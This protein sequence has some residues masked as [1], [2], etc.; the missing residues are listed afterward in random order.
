MGAVVSATVPRI[1]MLRL[2]ERADR[3]QARAQLWKRAA[4]HNRA[5]AII[6]GDLVDRPPK[7][8]LQWWC[9][10]CGLQFPSMDAMRTH[11]GT[12]PKHPASQ[13]ATAAEEALARVVAVLED[14]GCSADDFQQGC[15][16]CHAL[17]AARRQP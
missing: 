1:E 3:W 13:R 15:A 14:M 8:T 5:V 6:L 7:L 17:A 4:K 10:Y 2:L 16:G 9:T 12:C 11:A